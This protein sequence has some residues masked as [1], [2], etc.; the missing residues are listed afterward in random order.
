MKKVI[1]AV[2]IAAISTPALAMFGNPQSE[3][4]PAWYCT[5]NMQFNNGES[6]VYDLNLRNVMKSAT[7]TD[8][9]WE[10]VGKADSTGGKLT[11]KVYDLNG[12][13]TITYYGTDGN[14]FG[15]GDLLCKPKQ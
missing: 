9:Q 15:K 12:R 11:A 5:T 10:F 2:V 8:H 3:K 14:E 6:R 1:L 13:G 4:V 7:R